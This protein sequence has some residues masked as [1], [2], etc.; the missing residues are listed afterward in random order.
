MLAS[1]VV[2]WYRSTKTFSFSQWLR[3]KRN[4]GRLL[5]E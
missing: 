4:S 3:N 5:R 1:H 2:E